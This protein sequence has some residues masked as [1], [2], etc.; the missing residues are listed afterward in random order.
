M[1]YGIR[2][3]ARPERWNGNTVVQL[4]ETRNFG[5]WEEAMNR[6][7]EEED[8]FHGTKAETESHRHHFTYLPLCYRR[9]RRN[10]HRQCRQS[11]Q[12]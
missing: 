4:C 3:S 6:Y 1:S 9:H 10:L 8:R 11:L 7:C 2:L 12:L 5:Y